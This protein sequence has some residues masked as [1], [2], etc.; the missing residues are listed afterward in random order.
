MMPS[1]S[2]YILLVL[3]VIIAL[4][5][6]SQAVATQA[7]IIMLADIFTLCTCQRNLITL[8]IDNVATFALE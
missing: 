7:V 4:A 6:F 5:Q 1:Y 8:A 3:P 2:L